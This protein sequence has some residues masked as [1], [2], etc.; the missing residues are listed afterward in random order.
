MRLVQRK[1]RSIQKQL[2][3][4]LDAVR[5]DIMQS[6]I[7]DFSVAK[8]DGV[9]NNIR[10][11]LEGRLADYG[12]DLFSAN[13]YSENRDWLSKS[14]YSFQNGYCDI[15]SIRKDLDGYLQLHSLTS[16]NFDVRYWQKLLSEI[17]QM[18]RE[19]EEEISDF[20]HNQELVRNQVLTDWN[21]KLT[22]AENNWVLDQIQKIRNELLKKFRDKLQNLQE[23]KNSFDKFGLW[24]D[25]SYGNLSVQDISQLKYW[26]EYLNQNPKVRELCEMLGR[27]QRSAKKL[28]K[29]I[30]KVTRTYKEYVKDY[31][32]KEEITGLKY[33]NELSNLLPQELGI[34]GDETLDVIF[35]YKFAESQL[36]CFEMTGETPIS[37]EK[38]EEEV[39]MSE[40]DEAKGPIII[41]VDTSGSMAGAP[42]NIAKT[43]SLFMA[44]LA[45]KE[46][47]NC[48]LINFST[49]IEFFDFSK[50]MGI[51][52]LIHFLGMSFHGG[53]DVA[54]ALVKAVD[55]M[56]TEN[57]KKS[58]LLV[59]SD[60]VMGNLNDGIMQGIENAKKNKNRF[61]SLTIGSFNLNKSLNTIFENQWVYD[62]YKSDVRELVVN[63]KKVMES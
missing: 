27:M 36:M 29:E 26:A 5:K 11:E 8:E 20:R 61:F 1:N 24:F 41:C 14:A 55:I 58:D 39:R 18:P 33:S 2:S 30:I 48:F 7:Q 6:L 28:K 47:R 34:L 10:K 12:N 40:E 37:K 49:G 56:A 4:G 22:I 44:S 9:L 23:I 16:D 60:F 35:D 46:N 45:H 31:T 19:T 53:T 62:T 17:E 54:P 42:E 59:I 32:A 63:M 25:L 51:N 38:E 21:T 13:P 52:E 3:S 50:E 57:Y 15:N 43:I